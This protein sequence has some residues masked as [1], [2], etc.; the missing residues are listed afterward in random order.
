MQ[1]ESDHEHGDEHEPDGQREDRGQV[2]P[3]LAFARLAC[4]V[5]EQRRDEQDQEELGV[6][7]DLGHVRH[8]QRG[9][10]ADSD[11]DE[12]QRNAAD[13]RALPPRR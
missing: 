3:Q 11:L 13:Q 1:G 10:K 9:D 7:V 2:V 5:E 8:D 4:L 6:D 12:R